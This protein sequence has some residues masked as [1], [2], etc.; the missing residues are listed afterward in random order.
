MLT[1]VKQ[2]SLLGVCVCVCVVCVCARFRSRF[3]D[4]QHNCQPS[5]LSAT[6]CMRDSRA[7]CLKAYAG[8]IG[9]MEE[10]EIKEVE[11][12]ER[13]N[14]SAKNTLRAAQMT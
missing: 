2:F 8:L 11:E 4:F 7:M 6:G 5:P 14:S 10:K 13:G 3:A 9:E 12:A 1:D